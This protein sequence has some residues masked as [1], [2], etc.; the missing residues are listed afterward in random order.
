M[1][2]KDQT[3]DPGRTDD[4]TIWGPP[5]AFAA[6]VIGVFAIGVFAIDDRR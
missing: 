5:A 4:L 2:G 1:N 3:G 6:I